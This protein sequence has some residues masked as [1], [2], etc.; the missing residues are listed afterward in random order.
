[1]GFDFAS[2]TMKIVVGV[3]FL[4]VLLVELR[5]LRKER[6]T[7]GENRDRFS[8]VVILLSIF[9]PLGLT[10][11]FA[12]NGKGTIDYIYSYWGLAL[13]LA[14]FALRQWSIHVLGRFFTPVVSLQHGQRVIQQGPYRHLRHPSYTGLL[15]ELVGLSLA[16]SNIYG[17][18]AV[19][20]VLI[21]AL[22]YRIEIEEKV[23]EQAFGDEYLFYKEKTKRLIPFLY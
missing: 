16:L 11:Y 23:L 18:W 13:I 4:I 20:L 6:L 17:V 21:P 19:C 2:E 10:F 15:M 1:M 22:I 12:Y 8:L 3:V 9:V 5:I 14:G 7:A